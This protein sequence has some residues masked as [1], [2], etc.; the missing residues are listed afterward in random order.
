MRIASASAK[1]AIVV[2][3]VLLGIAEPGFAQTSR[4][5]L[6]TR[7]RDNATE[8]VCG[9]GAVEGDEECD[10]GNSVGGDGCAANCTI[11][12]TADCQLA[13]GSSAAIQTKLFLIP[14]PLSGSE[15][16]AVGQTRA[17]D[18]E[19]IRPVAM[20]AGDLH[21]DPIVIPGVA[22]ACLRALP[23]AELGPGNVATGA[24]GCTDS[25]LPQVD[26]VFSIDHDISD[27]DPD[28]STG[29]LED[30]SSAH[31]H[32]GACNGKPAISFSGRGGSGS[33][34]L[35]LN[36]SL[37]FIADGG[38]CGL[39]SGDLNLYGPDGIPCTDDD[40]GQ[41]APAILPVTTGT[42][43]GEV[44]DVN[45]VHGPKIAPGQICTALPCTA[46]TTGDRVSCTEL[47][48]GVVEATLVTAQGFIDEFQL[49]DN[50]T[51]MR[52]VCGNG[53]LPNTPTATPTPTPTTTKT[54]TP[55]STT[56]NP[57]A[58]KK[59]LPFCGN[60]VV[61]FYEE[62]DDGNT[63]G[64]DGCAANCTIESRR[65]CELDSG[66]TS[67][68][69]TPTLAI[70]FHLSGDEMFTT[71]RVRL[72]DPEK[73]APVVIEPEDV[74]FDPVSVPGSF[75]ICV[76]GHASPQLDGNYARGDIGCGSGLP[77][78]DYRD[79]VDHNIGV[80][81]ING[82]TAEE[83]AADGGTVEDGSPAHPHTG[84]CNGPNLLAFADSGPR[85]ST[86]LDESR[87]SISMIADGGACATADG[88][89]ALYGPD[90]IACTDDDP[91]QAAALD[92]PLTSGTASAQILHVD[93]GASVLGPD[94]V[95]AGTC[96]TELTGSPAPCDAL[97]VNAPGELGGLT[98]VAAFPSLDKGQLGDTVT[99][100][101]FT[102]RSS[103]SPT[104][105]PSR[106]PT[107]TRPPTP[108]STPFKSRTPTPTRTKT[109]P[110][111]HIRIGAA[112]IGPGQRV[113]V[114]VSLITSG[115]AVSATENDIVVSDTSVL[116]IDL[117]T[118]RANPT[119]G[120]TLATAMVSSEPTVQH[121][122]F[123][124]QP[125]SSTA[126]IPDGPLY[127]CAVRIA[128][129]ALSGTYPLDNEM[130]LAFDGAGGE[131]Q[132]VVGDNGGIGIGRLIKTCPGDC[133]GDGQVSIDELLAGVN[134]TLGKGSIVDCLA[135]DTDENDRVT[136][137]ELT[138]G[139]NAALDGCP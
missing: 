110:I 57:T 128:P 17:S 88:D 132:P 32:A 37:S 66:A 86:V 105:S 78:V 96:T 85:G 1:A 73:I 126:P 135:F 136:V 98:T 101:T 65:A 121:L 26:Y 127:S 14:F 100:L 39:A 97:V 89:P 54:P 36:A 93:D 130:P 119:I 61:D 104:P 82:F 18:A 129:S 94:A 111:V 75:C 47:S 109:P 10:D 67:T 113:A 116:S 83:C 13:A 42:A 51:T 71:G 87:T 12:D 133:D 9:N 99:T 41:Q 24:V 2:S 55:P 137:D 131:I 90:G 23:N 74:H 114:T 53:G 106:T 69:Q 5:R 107:R 112:V 8:P 27:V 102:C 120:K 70:P 29:T 60:G 117:E 64:G 138:R 43:S 31:P 34:L 28:C 91:A 7:F 52:L 115:V 68:I 4:V 77:H 40:P 108:S 11:E 123:L 48:N 45:D 25:G 19:A 63:V 134:L 35:Q 95:C 80:V 125:G 38:L 49:G 20:R 21:V 22:C 3:L 103:Q 58:T 46:A 30:G 62:C 16:W 44:I 79:S 118:C 81:G 50:V 72:D 92:L 15:T 122:R 76:R 59:G 56:P 84:V 6:S 124:I 139:V 33:A